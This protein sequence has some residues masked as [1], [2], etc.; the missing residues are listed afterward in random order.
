LTCLHLSENS[1]F[2]DISFSLELR[3]KIGMRFQE[4]DFQDIFIF[5]F[6]VTKKLVFF[7]ACVKDFSRCLSLV[8][9]AVQLELLPPHPQWDM[10]HMIR[11]VWAQLVN[12]H[13]F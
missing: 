4:S 7:A 3:T 6:K 1:D 5:F 9:A 2:K 13:A 11:T 10:P 8:P 12:C